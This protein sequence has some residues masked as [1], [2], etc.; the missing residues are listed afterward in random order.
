[1]AVHKAIT[2][3]N[4]VTPYRILLVSPYAVQTEEVINSIIDICNNIPDKPL[5]SSK[6][7][8]AWKLTFTNGTILMGFTASTNGDQ[9]RRTACGSYYIR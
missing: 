4:S 5:Q 7:T 6:Q 9:I 3:D 2:A 8:P 1:M